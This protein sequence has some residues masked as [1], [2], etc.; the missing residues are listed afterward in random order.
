MSYINIFIYVSHLHSQVFIEHNLLILSLGT[1]N[2]LV[3]KKVLA[4]I[5][6]S[7]NLHSGVCAVTG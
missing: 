6:P 5:L 7:W 4:Q 3:G 1:G 2:E